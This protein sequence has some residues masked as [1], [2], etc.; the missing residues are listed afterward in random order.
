MVI[1]FM[2]SSLTK[3]QKTILIIAIV[4]SIL[5]SCSR[6]MN[7]P[8][9]ESISSIYPWWNY[10]GYILYDGYGAYAEH[11]YMAAFHPS[12]ENITKLKDFMQLYIHSSRPVFPIFITLF[13]VIIQDILFSAFFV[14][15]IAG[16][17]CIY[18][19]NRIITTHFS[20]REKDQFYLNLLFVSHVSIIGMLGR[21]MSD[22][23]A[24]FLLLS[25]IHL[26]YLYNLLKKPRHLFLFIL[27][28]IFA[29]FTKTILAMLIFSIPLA[30][31][32]SRAKSIGRA[33]V[34]FLFYCVLPVFFV[35]IGLIIVRKH[36][37]N[38]SAITFIF[39][40]INGALSFDTNPQW[41]KYY[42]KSAILFLGIALQIYPLFVIFNKRIRSLKYML[43]LT[44]MGTYM[45]QRFIFA[46]FNLQ[47][48]RG[49]YGIP[50]VAGVLIL[51]Y[52]VIQRHI[53]QKRW[54]ALVYGMIVLNYA[55]WIGLLVKGA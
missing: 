46:G 55:V 47:Y 24:T 49:R 40:C 10:N 9:R 35:I 36:C 27:T 21:P 38:L 30:I 32:V 14:N 11:L 50:L 2:F 1:D 26:S 18:M 45:L 4:F 23:I 39:N 25:A 20:Y 17:L 53:H 33:L 12:A 13:Y 42:S 15:I 7:D 51:A 5:L 44:W 16:L 41:L 34:N 54:K 19:F 28:L 43:H 29:F 37:P 22:T 52:P 48:S 6:W 3:V 31:I 8:H